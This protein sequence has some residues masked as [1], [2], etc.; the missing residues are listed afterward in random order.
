MELYVKAATGSSQGVRIELY[1]NALTK[2]EESQ[3]SLDRRCRESEERCA[4]L[5]VE[6]QETVARLEKSIREVHSR[7]VKDQRE[8]GVAHIGRGR[9]RGESGSR[10]STRQPL[11]SRPDTPDSEVCQTGSLPP[12]EI[13]GVKLVQSCESTAF[14]LKD[15]N[16]SP[17]LGRTHTDTEGSWHEDINLEGVR[18][19]LITKAERGSTIRSTRQRTRT[20]RV[21]G[22]GSLRIDGPLRADY[23]PGSEVR[24]LMGTEQVYSNGSH[25]WVANAGGIDFVATLYEPSVSPRTPESGRHG[26]TTQ[27]PSTTV[28]MFGASSQESSGTGSNETPPGNRGNRDGGN[29]GAFGTPGS[30][31]GEPQT[32]NSSP[33]TGSQSAFG[34]PGSRAGE[35]QRQNSLPTMGGQ[36][37]FGTSGL[38]AGANPVSQTTSQIRDVSP[39]Y[40]DDDRTLGKYFTRGSQGRGE[41]DRAAILREIED[42]TLL[43]QY[44]ID[45]EKWQSLEA[46]MPKLPQG[47]TDPKKAGLYMKAVIAGV[48]KMLIP[49][50]KDPRYLEG[51]CFDFKEVAF[52]PHAE[53]HTH[54]Y[55]KNSM[56]MPQASYDRANA[57]RIEP[58]VRLQL[59]MHY[60]RVLPPDP[61]EQDL[62]QEAFLNPPGECQTATGVLDEIVRCHDHGRDWGG[63]IE[64]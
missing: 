56:G 14:S 64:R 9:S 53:S 21:I 10:R 63:D 42:G 32:Q 18:R 51:M 19:N 57:L 25:F 27:T 29:L 40:A 13:R 33:P 43:T 44:P 16:P 8:Q 23:A 46:S 50:R 31:A 39:V 7:P 11:A 48:H 36:G 45:K 26:E 49:Y 55:V 62:V 37:T 52:H 1:A 38:L 17:S 35:P 4:K 5:M 58:P 12:P 41:D 28:P 54:R 47:S 3:K 22:H 61:I 30:R 20:H 34:T 24:T 6:H 60:I 15:N 2:V 59:L